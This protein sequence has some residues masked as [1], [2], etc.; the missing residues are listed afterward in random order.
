MPSQRTGA[1]T[2]VRWGTASALRRSL[3]EKK[4]HHSASEL[5]WLLRHCLSSVILS[6][7]RLKAIF[8]RFDAN[9][10]GSLNRTELPDAIQM[11]LGQSL[12]PQELETLHDIVDS[13]NDKIR[14]VDFI[15]YFAAEEVA[16]KAFNTTTSNTI[17]TVSLSPDMRFIA[18]GGMNCKVVVHDL[19]SSVLCFERTCATQT[20]G[21]A[22]ANHAEFIAIGSYKGRVEWL[23]LRT[24]S[25]KVQD[26]PGIGAAF[27]KGPTI[28]YSQADNA[29][30]DKQKVLF[31]WNHGKD[32]YSVCV[33]KDNEELAVGGSDNA[34]TIYELRS[35]AR[36]YRFVQEASVWSVA[37][38]SMTCYALEIDDGTRLETVR[39]VR[40]ID[41]RQ[42]PQPCLSLSGGLN[43]QAGLIPIG[44]SPKSTNTPGVPV[45]VDTGDNDNTLGSRLVVINGVVQG[46]YNERGRGDWADLDSKLDSLSTHFGLL[47]LVAISIALASAQVC[48]SLGCVAG[49]I[50]LSNRNALAFELLATLIFL[51][52][53]TMRMV[54]WQQLRSLP[55]F[56]AD[57]ICLVDA[58]VVITDI[59]VLA[60]L[61]A[62]RHAKCPVRPVDDRFK[63]IGGAGGATIR[64]TLRILRI[65]RLVRFL[66]A[67]RILR[68]LDQTRP[69]KLS[70]YYVVKYVD[71]SLSNGALLRHMPDYRITAKDIKIQLQFLRQHA[72]LYMNDANAS[73]ISVVRG[74]ISYEVD[75]VCSKF[76]EA[77]WSA[78]IS[79]ESK[80]IIGCHVCSE[81]AILPISYDVTVRMQASVTTFLE[82]FCRECSTLNEARPY[83]RRGTHWQS[84]LRC[85]LRSDGYTAAQPPNDIVSCRI[86]GRSVHRRE[87]NQIPLH[88]RRTALRRQQQ[89]LRKQM[90]Q[91]LDE[92][93]PV[94][95]TITARAWRR[96][97]LRYVAIGGEAQFVTIWQYDLVRTQVVTS[98]GNSRS[99]N[100][101]YYAVA[102][103]AC[104]DVRT[105]GLCAQVRWRHNFQHTVECVSL[106]ADA[107]RV[108]ASNT[109]G[110]TIVYDFDHRCVVF[111]WDDVQQVF[112]V[113]LST[114]GD[115]LAIAG[116]SKC[117]RCFHVT[118]GAQIFAKVAHDRQRACT[119]SADGSIVAAGG[120][121]GRLV[122]SGLQ[123]GAE[124]FPLE[125]HSDVYSV[126]VDA[127]GATLALG[128]ND[129]TCRCYETI[130]RVPKELWTAQHA[131][132]V[133]VVAVSPNGASVAAGDYSLYRCLLWD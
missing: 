108:A 127:A 66:R 87:I 53:A 1:W 25:T 116:A 120:F 109:K 5:T 8:E 12:R 48:C 72:V 115:Q 9:C 113:S 118:S 47:A 41:R 24:T 82:L 40:F 6:K 121:D 51:S 100:G 110:H 98:S 62:S 30:S 86:L 26:A 77:L 33:S 126:A 83:H 13:T 123:H 18:H 119:L 10:D 4:A 112:A 76:H 50:K 80:M 29:T 32:I 19:D 114:S 36:R 78:K 64:E 99:S 20:G 104:V 43:E 39:D 11:L 84:D 94:E 111:R 23:Q 101:D 7:P 102:K 22:L 96:R 75:T 67:T 89:H 130:G 95:L 59:A 35:G 73:M 52:E 85:E 93:A 132:K 65:L 17:T 122:A 129:G 15:S 14:L 44:A 54:C 16:M 70:Q 90:L 34:V 57:P 60:T 49:S 71:I 63:L 106:S 27:L 38:S 79:N 131:S 107:R 3:S 45:P 97:E 28:K 42:R 74:E 117:V 31:E 58:A 2:A 21:V 91:Q 124:M 55:G 68:A 61:A 88:H 81:N 133:W 37:L 128:C 92:G 56:F 69:S 125:I 105:P 103:V 46:S